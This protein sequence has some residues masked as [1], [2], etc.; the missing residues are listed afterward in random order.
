MALRAKKPET[1]EKRLKVLFFGPAGS[2][3]TTAAI[4]FPKP[5][6]IDTEAGAENAKYVKLLTDAGGAYLGPR[7]GA[8][9]FDV[10]LEQVTSLLSEK[11]DYRTLII[12]PLT[13]IYNEMCD[14]SAEKNGTE[15]GRHK[16]DPD[17]KI[18]HLLTLLTRL[19][20]NVIITSHAKPNW[21]R[22]KDSKGKEVA[23]QEGITF[24][25]Y[26]R[27]DYLFDLVIEVGK[28][29]ADRVGIVRKTR[30]EGFPEAEVMPFNYPEIAK[31]YG[32]LILEREAVAVTLAT[33]EQV[34]EAGRLVT[35]LNI[36]PETVEKWFDKGQAA[37]WQEMKSDDAAKCIAWMQ[38]R[39]VG[40]EK[41]MA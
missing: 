26:G 33:A 23:A 8:T 24:D 22:T 21:V 10:L 19:D 37:N 7:E 18:K 31:R 14:R 15:F 20:M 27:L 40:T 35:L 1:T 13:V 25:C 30:C 38:A 34:A 16:V 36:A 3:K 32:G 2:G 9:D 4:Q 12:D 5:Y 41:G 11:H 28:R 29:G 17:R 6:L 39:I